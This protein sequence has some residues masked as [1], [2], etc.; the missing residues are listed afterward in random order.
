MSDRVAPP[1]ELVEPALTRPV[2]NVSSSHLGPEG[3]AESIEVGPDVSRSRIASIELPRGEKLRPKRTLEGSRSDRSSQPVDAFRVEISAEALEVGGEQDDV[4]LIDMARC[5]A[6]PSP[7]APDCSMGRLDPVELDRPVVKPPLQRGRTQ[8]QAPV[9]QACPP[10]PVGPE[11]PFETG[12]RPRDGDSADRRRDTR[13]IPRHAPRS[14]GGAPASTPGSPRVHGGDCPC[15]GFVYMEHQEDFERRMA[16]ALVGV[17]EG[18]IRDEREFQR[19][20]AS[21]VELECHQPLAVIAYAFIERPFRSSPNPGVCRGQL[22]R[23]KARR[24]DAVA[25]ARPRGHARCIDGRRG[26]SDPR[27]GGPRTGPPGRSRSRDLRSRARGR[28]RA[29]GQNAA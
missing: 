24:R 20:G 1:A 18:M 7:T 29:S 23:P 4:R 6:T 28:P 13:G 10:G 27:G 16:D 21:I 9:A 26:T 11:K 2:Q 25:F 3:N 17:D 15:P 14:V 19:P 22:E 12:R 8:S 5:P